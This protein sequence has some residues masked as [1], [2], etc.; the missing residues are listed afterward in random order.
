M[1]Q[2]N[3]CDG[4]GQNDKGQIIINPDNISHILPMGELRGNGSIIYMMDNLSKP[5]HVSDSFRS[6]S[7]LLEVD[8]LEISR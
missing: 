8:Y 4:T 2:L 7:G 5:F 6:V 3:L 1:I